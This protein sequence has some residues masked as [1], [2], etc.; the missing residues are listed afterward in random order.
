MCPKMS[1]CLDISLCIFSSISSLYPMLTCI[2]VFLLSFE[3]A[4]TD[5]YLTLK[6]SS[7]FEENIDR[8]FMRSNKG[9]FLSVASCSTL[10]LNP[11]QLK[12]LLKSILKI[13]IYR[14][15][16]E[17]VLAAPDSAPYRIAAIPKA[18]TDITIPIIKILYARR[19]NLYL[20]PS[21]TPSI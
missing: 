20:R 19:I 7:R 15:E 16:P 1:S 3:K 13:F 21:T 18:I 17:G 4:Y 12:S 2:R 14:G 6:N 11:S 8:N 10:K 9:T 5:G